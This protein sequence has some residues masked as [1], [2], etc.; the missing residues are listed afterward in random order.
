MSVTGEDLLR[1]LIAQLEASL[2][3]ARAVLESVVAQ[4]QQEQAEIDAVALDDAE[5]EKLRRAT[6]GMGQGE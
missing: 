2:T 3:T 6:E 5:Q 1:A 4:K